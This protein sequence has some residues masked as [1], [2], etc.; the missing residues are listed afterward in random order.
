MV[1]RLGAEA[2]SLQDP[3]ETTER[4]IRFLKTHFESAKAK[5]LIVGMSGGVD[6]SVTATLCARAV[7]G[8]RTL[9]YFLSEDETKNLKSAK[10]AEHVARENR[11]RFNSLDITRLVKTTTSL[12]NGSKE[13][14]KIPLG[15]IKARLRAMILYYFANTRKGLVVGT[16]DKSEIMLGYFTKYGDGA[17][18]LAPLADM[19]KTT[20]RDLARHLKLPVRIYSKESSPELWPGQTAENELGLDY[21]R[22]DLVLW[23]LERWMPVSE[24]S[25]SLEVPLRTVERLRKRWLAS[26]H[27][28]RPPLTM[29]LGFRTTGQDLRIPFDLSE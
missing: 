9:G 1:S 27:K 28:R 7:G 11:I 29:K 15:N 17:S 14:G 21:R 18:D 19:Y 2:L 24:I 13:F 3:T 22:I 6:S 8:P 5:C 10:D 25:R 20:I 16:G 4:L 23:G 12:V 26:E